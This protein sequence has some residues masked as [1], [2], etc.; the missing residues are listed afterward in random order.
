MTCG[1]YICADCTGNYKEAW[2]SIGGSPAMKMQHD[3]TDLWNGWHNPK[4]TFEQA[5]IFIDWSNAPEN[6]DSW[7]RDMPETFI[8]R[9]NKIFSTWDD[10]PTYGKYPT[11]EIKPET[12]NGTNHYGIGT[13]AWCWVACETEDEANEV[14]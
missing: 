13:Y 4:M 1:L 2:F 9:E 12:I 8:V 7:K 5:R 14:Y 6:F 3:P 11:E 10:D